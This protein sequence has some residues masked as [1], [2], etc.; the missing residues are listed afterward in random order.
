LAT[1]VGANDSDCPRV[2]RTT[3]LCL[4]IARVLSTMIRTEGF[5]LD[6][7]RSYQGFAVSGY[8]IEV[9]AVCV[10]RLDLH[11]NA[12]PI[13]IEPKTIK[14]HRIAFAL[15]ETVLHR[16]VEPPPKFIDD[17]LQDEST[18]LKRALETRLEVFVEIVALRYLKIFSEFG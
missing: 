7:R 4:K 12:V 10:S 9:Y 17:V 6:L 15:I 16:V 18:S 2:L 5:V 14:A 1:S 13:R 11:Y 8:C 3:H